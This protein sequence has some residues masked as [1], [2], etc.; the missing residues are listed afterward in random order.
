MDNKMRIMAEE[1]ENTDTGEKVT[2]I[3]VMI[4]GKLKQVF[5]AMIK[6]SDGE[7]SY[8]EM[9]QEVLVMGIDE[10]IKRLK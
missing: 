8:L 4:D 7:K 10:Y 2:G 5:D 6:K 3:T 1:F 9:L